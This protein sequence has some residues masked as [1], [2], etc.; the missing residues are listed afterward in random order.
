MTDFPKFVYKVSHRDPGE[1][2]KAAMSTQTHSVAPIPGNTKK[3]RVVEVF[4]FSAYGFRETEP[5]LRKGII[6][7]EQYCTNWDIVKDV[8]YFGKEFSE[9]KMRK[10]KLSKLDPYLMVWKNSHTSYVIG[11]HVSH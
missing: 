7:Q 8:S 5:E 4:M 10:I 2:L 6:P 1:G 11:C 3:Q 9:K